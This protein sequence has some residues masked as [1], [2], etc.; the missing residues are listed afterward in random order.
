MEVYGEFLVGGVV[1]VYVL[2]DVEVDL[3]IDEGISLVCEFEEISEDIVDGRDG[4]FGD[5]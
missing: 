4:E 3:E 5:V 1:G 2:V